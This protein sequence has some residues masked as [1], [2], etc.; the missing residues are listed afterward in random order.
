MDDEDQLTSSDIV[1]Q[2]GVSSL[3]DLDS[4][5]NVGPVSI[6]WM[7]NAVASVLLI[8][9]CRGLIFLGNKGKLMKRYKRLQ[10]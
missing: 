8:F 3:D 10:S 4:D 2:I 1:Q 7:A 5:D 9:S 6:Y